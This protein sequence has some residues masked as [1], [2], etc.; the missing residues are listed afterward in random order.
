MILIILIISTS[1]FFIINYL[2]R[3][4]PLNKDINKC[5]GEQLDRKI[6]RKT[7]FPV[8]NEYFFFFEEVEIPNIK[9]DPNTFLDYE[10]GSFFYIYRAKH[11][12]I[13]YENYMRFDLV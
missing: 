4:I 3:I 2:R 8:T 6:I 1:V 9:I 7:Y 12:K 13:V 5:I 10:E 11:S